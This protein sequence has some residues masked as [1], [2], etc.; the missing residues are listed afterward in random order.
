MAA[1]IFLAYNLLVIVWGGLVRATGSGAGCG[2]H[3]PLCNGVWVPQHP[4]LRRFIELTH[5]G[6]SD[7]ALLGVVVLLFW[8]RKVS[9]EKSLM[10]A[11]ATASLCLMLSEAAIGAGLV[12]LK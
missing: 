10:R 11:G 3:W 5:R 2:D 6:M 8:S 12:L 4:Q 7:L 9:P 1:W